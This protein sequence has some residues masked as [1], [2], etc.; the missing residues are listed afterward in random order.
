MHQLRGLGVGPVLVQAADRQGFQG[1]IQV[2]AQLIQVQHVGQAVD[3]AVR[4]GERVDALG[5]VQGLPF[6]QVP[7]QLAQ[8]QRI[9][10]HPFLPALSGLLPAVMAPVKHA[11]EEWD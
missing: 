9:E 7:Y 10:R 2:P 4:P 5:L 8:D 1:V 6:L 3:V 11:S